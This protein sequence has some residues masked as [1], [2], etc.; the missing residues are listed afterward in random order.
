MT[1]D[2]PYR[3]AISNEEAA[4]EIR[5]ASGTHFDPAIVDSFLETVSR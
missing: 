1:A 2:R 5:K 3:T 4:E